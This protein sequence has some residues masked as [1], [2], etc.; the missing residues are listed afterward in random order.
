MAH[1]H[2]MAHTHSYAH[3]HGVPG[4][5]HKHGTGSMSAA[6]GAGLYDAQSIGYIAVGASGSA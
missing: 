2:T 5:K 3:T 6:I 1:T 4:V